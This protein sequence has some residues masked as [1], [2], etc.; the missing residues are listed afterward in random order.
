MTAPDWAVLRT[1]IVARLRRIADGHEAEDIAQDALVVSLRRWARGG[2]VVCWLAFATRVAR[3]MLVNAI[4]RRRRSPQLLPDCDLPIAASADGSRRP[5]IAAV[6]AHVGPALSPLEVRVLVAIRT[7]GAAT[8]SELAVALSY[9]RD[10]T[11]A[12]RRALNAITEKWDRS[13]R[14]ER[15]A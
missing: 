2:A 11:R 10:E 13:V 14:V 5:T 12:L 3:R 6:L 7:T 1:V 8:M 15:Q 9:R 4:R